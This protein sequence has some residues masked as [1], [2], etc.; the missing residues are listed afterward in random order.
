MEKKL[1]LT[2]LLGEGRAGDLP[3]AV[4]RL[5]VQGL[6]CDSRQV[7]KGYLFAA[8]KGANTD[9]RQFIPAAIAKGASIIL[10][11]PGTK[12][13]VTDNVFLLEE[14][15]P[16]KLFSQLAARFYHKQPEHVVAV[17]GTNGK[18]SVAYFFQQLWNITGQKAASMGTIGITGVAGF[19]GEE[20]LTT[21]DPV[22]LHQTLAALMEKGVGYLGM[23]ASSHGLDQYRL[24]GVTLQAAAFTNLSRDHLDYHATMEEYFKAKLRLFSELLPA[25]GTAVVNADVPEYHAIETVARQRNHHILSY[26]RAEGASLRIHEIIREH[27]GQRVWFTYG[28]KPQTVLLPLL[29]EFQVYN[30][31]CSLG[32]ALATGMEIKQ[33]VGALAKLSP[34]PGRMERVANPISGY[35]VFVDY[36]HTP[37]ALEKALHELRPYVK[38]ELWV[39]FGCGGDRDKG[40]RPQMGEVAARL[41]DRIVV[42]DDNPRSEDPAVIRQ[43]II[44]ACPAA[45]EI[46]D[47][48]EAIKYAVKQLQPGDILLISGKGHEKTQ[49]VG[50]KVYPFDDVRVAGEVLDTVSKV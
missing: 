7:E 47:R 41:A 11:E 14:H 16:R 49:K 46:G 4:S 39:V 20:S 12:L 48:G 30:A 15:N 22:K 19:E 9:G 50:D 24:D 18:T 23:E 29:G 2:D 45:K 26:G 6:S 17:T 44:V 37:D 28:G 8:W 34:A 33:A 13:P 35:A 10:A 32:L 36:A 40:K 21:P 3:A 43:A 5:D 1:Q 27:Y 25:G 38:G 42:T 31:L